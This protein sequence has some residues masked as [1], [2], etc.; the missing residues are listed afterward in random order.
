LKAHCYTGW[1]KKDQALEHF[2]LYMKLK[3][4][5]AEA[6]YERGVAYGT[7]NDH[8]SAVRDFDIALKM[9]HELRSAIAARGWSY[10]LLAKY[11]RAIEDFD[12]VLKRAPD[13]V[14]AVCQRGLAYFK[15]GKYDEAIRDLHSAQKIDPQ[16]LFV[17]AYLALYFSGCA[18]PKMRDGSK[19]VA[20]AKRACERERWNNYYFMDILAGSYSESGQFDQAVKWEKQALSLAQDW[21]KAGVQYRLKWYESRKKFADLPTD[22]SL[23]PIEK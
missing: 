5:E 16:Y 22:K 7:W 11:D 10:I 18:D 13:D 20:Y 23:P 12:A 15:T 14:E 1:L 2:D 19:A 8:A 17:D 9:N 4:N 6:Y 3:P 21:D